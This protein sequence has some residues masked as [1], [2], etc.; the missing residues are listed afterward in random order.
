ME[1]SC[2]KSPWHELIKQKQQRSVAVIHRM[3]TSDLVGQRTH[4]ELATLLPDH[5]P[6]LHHVDGT[7]VDGVVC[8]VPQPVLVTL[9]DGDVMKGQFVWMRIKGVKKN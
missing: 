5:L 3:K 9:T 7:Q 1:L 2:R 4:P 6:V 8:F